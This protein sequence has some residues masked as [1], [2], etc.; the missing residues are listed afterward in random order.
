M[1]R[2]AVMAAL[3][4]GLA[5]G[6]PEPEPLPRILGASPEG[7]DASTA[8][9]A[10]VRFSAPAD[11]EGLVDGRLLT[12]VPAAALREAI[13]AV[14]S[15]A[16]AAGMAAAVPI[17]TVLE[18]E[19]HRAVLRPLAP[20]RALSSYALV[21]SS[22]ARASDGRSFLD[23]DGRRRTFVAA[24]RTGA[25]PGPPP[26]P[27]LTE[28]RA[29]A[30]TPEAGGEYVELANLGDGALDP[31]GWRLAKRSASGALSSCA[32][33][34][35]PVPA[36][37]IALVVGGAWDGR[38]ALPPGVALLR[39]GAAAL[40]GG[41]ANDRPPEILLLDPAGAIVATIGGAGA[42]VCAAA[43]EKAD[44]AGADEPA[45]LSCSEGEGTPGALP[46]R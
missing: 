24:F 5:C 11:P 27:A 28:V 35:V 4:A 15:D 43:L 34:G 12:L 41:I 16:G 14:E 13:T 46:A 40:L 8:G 2:V 32:I 25:P 3:L 30:A 29:D 23:P 38:Y 21:V 10:E 45:N 9:E 18:E 37:G 31:V 44:P 6:M 39:C 33:D 20:L 19:G 1:T 7:E 26:R 22:R 36:G 42:P 17:R